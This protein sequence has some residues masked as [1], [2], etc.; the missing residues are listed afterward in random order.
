M[1]ITL[2]KL[3]LAGIGSVASTYEKAEGIVDE[4]VKKG[5]IAVNEGKE[6]NEELKKKSDK[7]R[8]EDGTF[9]IQ[10]LKNALSD[11]NLATK[12]DIDTLKERI[13]KLEN[14]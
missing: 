14:K 10:S 5:E 7:Y 6:L 2:R 11:L 1:E 4:L 13:E 8:S 12:Q 3:L 9:N